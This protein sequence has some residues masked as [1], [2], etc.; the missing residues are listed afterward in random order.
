ME[1][2]RKLHIVYAGP[3]NLCQ[4]STTDLARGITTNKRKQSA[5]SVSVFQ[6]LKLSLDSVVSG[7]LI[8][9]WT[10]FSLV[11]HYGNSAGHIY[12]WEWS[13]VKELSNSK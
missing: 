9:P 10:F 3:T 2:T 12:H 11:Y 8:N 7:V 4:H 5:L 6:T 1:K 13:L